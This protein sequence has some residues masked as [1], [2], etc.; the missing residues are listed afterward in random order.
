MFHD[1]IMKKPILNS[2]DLHKQID[3][4]QQSEHCKGVKSCLRGAKV[5]IEIQ[6]WVHGFKYWPIH[7]TS[8]KKVHKHDKY[9]IFVG[10]Q[11]S[12]LGNYRLLL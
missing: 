8:M 11:I 2:Y 4:G 3:Q 9:A 5:W 12:N 10:N 1:N 6:G 7:C